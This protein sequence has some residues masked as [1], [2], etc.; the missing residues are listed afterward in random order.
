M[1]GW[2]DRG[3]RTLPFRV[4]FRCPG[5][6]GARHLAAAPQEAALPHHAGEGGETQPGLGRGAQRGRLSRNSSLS[7]FRVGVESQSQG[8]P[9]PQNTVSKPEAR[10]SLDSF[11]F[12]RIEVSRTGRICCGKD[13]EQTQRSGGPR[14]PD[15]AEGKPDCCG[16]SLAVIRPWSP[17]LVAGIARSARFAPKLWA[18]SDPASRAQ[19][20]KVLRSFGS[21]APFCL[22]LILLPVRFCVLS[23]LLRCS[24]K[25]PE[26]KQILA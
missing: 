7:S 17:L 5:G 14:D 20:M 26:T 8:L 10:E 15:P 13:V 23:P 22:G 16:A 4:A 2:T 9:R 11:E 21:F 6:G 1:L 24:S 3:V 25:A 18:T 19:G 12:A